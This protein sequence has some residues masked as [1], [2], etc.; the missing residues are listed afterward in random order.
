M[1]W[2][3]CQPNTPE[4]ETILQLLE[5]SGEHNARHGGNRH[6]VETIPRNSAG[7]ETDV[8]FHL[9]SHCPRHKPLTQSSSLFLFPQNML[10][11]ICPRKAATTVTTLSPG[12]G[13]TQTTDSLIS[14]ETTEPPRTTT[15]FR[16][17]WETESTLSSST[18]TA[19][20][21]T[22]TRFEEQSQTPDT[23]A[24]ATPK[25]TQFL[26]PWEIEEERNKQEVS[27][28]TTSSTTTT[29]WWEAEDT[30]MSPVVTQTE[31][32]TTTTP[33][34]DVGEQGSGGD[35]GEDNDDD[36]DDG[37]AWWPNDQPRT[38]PS[39]RTQ[40]RALLDAFNQA[41]KRSFRSKRSLDAR[42]DSLTEPHQSSEL[43]EEEVSSK[44]IF[45]S[46]KMWL[47]HCRSSSGERFES[48]I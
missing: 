29:N 39:P 20:P 24:I 36:R 23:T 5:S 16:W 42:C 17:S 22:T 3:S 46:T 35:T 14:F 32:P 10:E 48:Q 38:R 11:T 1:F 47:F 43:V 25:T 40:Q 15:T 18:Q 2:Q 13:A 31:T 45:S 34:P 8:H 7:V 33:K 6:G 4:S 28:T 41:P 44:R 26:W 12:E 27:T 30:T 37:G 19:T 9:I 21:S